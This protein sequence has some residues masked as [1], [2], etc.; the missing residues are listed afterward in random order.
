VYSSPPNYNYAYNG[1]FERWGAGASAVPTGWTLAGAGASVARDAT[2]KKVGSYS[3][4]LTRAGTNCTLTQDVDLIAE[5]GPVGWWQGRRVT[6]GAWVRATVA[7]QAR[8]QLNDGVGTTSGADHTGGG[9]WEWL[10]V[11]RTLDAAATRVRPTFQV[12]VD[13]TAQVDGLVVFTAELADD[14]VPG[15]VIDRTVLAFGGRGTNPGGIGTLWL[16]TTQGGHRVV[17]NGSAFEDQAIVEAEI[18][19]AAP[20]SGVAR[21]LRCLRENA[22]AS[23]TSAFTLRKNTADTALTATIA[24]GARTASDVANEVE[25]AAG[26]ELAVKCV[27]GGA[28]PAANEEYRCT[29]EFER[30]P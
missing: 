3:A 9:A 16:G 6:L 11:T 2:N 26:D 4:A 7:S 25:I 10:T 17:W 22:T 14:F 15:E 27:V 8:L 20:F 23:L 24:G 29:I 1:N 5:H 19:I 30:R 28:T 13:G 12:R 18:T 21:N